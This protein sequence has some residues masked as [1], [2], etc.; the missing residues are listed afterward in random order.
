ATPSWRWWR[1]RSEC[2]TAPPGT[3]SK[4]P[5]SPKRAPQTRDPKSCAARCTHL[6]TRR[7]ETVWSGRG[8]KRCGPEKAREAL[9][10]RGPLR[11]FADELSEPCTSYRDAG[12]QPQRDHED[13]DDHPC[14]DAG[15]GPVEKA[16][17]AGALLIRRG[18]V[19]PA[20]LPG[21]R[22]CRDDGH[23][24][25]EL[26]HEGE[27]KRLRLAHDAELHQHADAGEEHQ[28][29]AGI[30]DSHYHRPGCVV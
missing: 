8:G 11:S 7:P 10:R 27:P 5:P 14:A 18:L 26:L 2:S 6:F 15:D 22:H 4:N 19:E 16:P 1:R 20:D 25:A 23:Q 21:Q 9:K 17:K 3:R 29:G 30:E 12:L 13:R 28:Y 24:A